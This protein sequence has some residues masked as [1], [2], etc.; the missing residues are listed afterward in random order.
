MLETILENK[1]IYEFLTLYEHSFWKKLIPSLLEIAIL[2]LKSSFNTLIFSEK[3]ID[4]I[5][6]DLKAKKTIIPN[7]N[8]KPKS[9]KE[10]EKEKE[11][12]HVI[13]YKPS[14][15]WRTIEGWGEPDN[16]L[17]HRYSHSWK[18][19]NKKKQKN[20]KSK[21]KNLIDNEK[22]NYYYTSSENN[23]INNYNINPKKRVNYAIS[24]DKNLVP[25]I[26]ES[27]I[28]KESK[29]GEKKIIQKMT[30]EEYEKKFNEDNQNNYSND[31]IYNEK[32]KSKKLFQSLGP[33][34]IKF[35]DININERNL[36]PY[37]SSCSYNYSNIKSKNRSPKLDNQNKM[38][39]N[40]YHYKTNYSTQRNNVNQN[41]IQNAKMSNYGNYKNG[42]QNNLIELNANSLRG[43]GKHY[44]KNK[45]S[46]NKK[47]LNKKYTKIRKKNNYI[48]IENYSNQEQNDK[49]YT[50]NN[51]KNIYLNKN[52]NSQKY[53][54][55]ERSSDNAQNSEFIGID[56]K[57]EKKIDE[58]EKNI[59]TTQNNVKNKNKK[60]ELNLNKNNN[61]ENFSNKL[62]VN[63]ISMEDYALKK[64][65]KNKKSKRNKLKSEK[66]EKIDGGNRTEINGEK[67]EQ[68]INGEGDNE[69]YNNEREFL[70]QKSNIVGKRQLIF[71]K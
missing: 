25:E 24:Y 13:Y 57:Y 16:I 70:S 47:A 60:N 9:I 67:E 2:N 66:Y 5:I 39:N 30:Q 63:I 62:K 32:N 48:N 18:Y 29:K 54:Y 50:Y 3:D 8:K 68:N 59:L 14:T 7:F 52:I 28:V 46:S 21:I 45:N 34:K 44:V 10:T 31:G 35:I 51:N 55:R 1:I 58:L 20:L 33:K 41:L 71:K 64:K 23:I 17:H 12:E 53:A 40:F 19:S 69:N 26:I 43:F 4:N 15:E 49:N 61:I 27:K 6:K 42:L 11:R 65:N 22:R 36:S 56:K 37:N 38:S